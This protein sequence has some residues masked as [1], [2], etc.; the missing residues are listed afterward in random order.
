MGL[1]YEGICEILKMSVSEALIH[2]RPKAILRMDE[3]QSRGSDVCFANWGRQ[4]V[5]KPNAMRFHSQFPSLCF[6]SL[7]ASFHDSTHAAMSPAGPDSWRSV[8]VE[9]SR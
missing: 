3:R 2:L 4:M 1:S 6:A 5:S 8:A 9:L 7:M